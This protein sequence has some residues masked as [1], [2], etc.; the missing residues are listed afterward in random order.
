MNARRAARKKE[1]GKK[2]ERGSR[3]DGDH[4][5]DRAEPQADPSDA[6]QQ[7]AFQIRA[8]QSGASVRVNHIIQIR[9][10]PM[11][12]TRFRHNCGKRTFMCRTCD[13][14]GGVVGRFSG[15]ML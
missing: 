6:E 3:H 9:F 15:N 14:P 13:M 12:M 11:S 5:P 10:N 7:I 4:D 8:F 1:S 2:E